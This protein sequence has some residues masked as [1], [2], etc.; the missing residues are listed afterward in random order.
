MAKSKAEYYFRRYLKIAPLGLALWR[1][2][3][4]KHL[5]R[6]KLPRP[7]L[8]VG[9]GFGEFALAF[10]DGKPVDVGIDILAKNL[11]NTV[12]TKK[13]KNLVIGDAREMP[14]SDNTFGSIFSISTYEHITHPDKLLKESYRVLRPGGIIFL[15][16]ETDEVDLNTFYRPLFKKIGIGS[17]SKWCTQ[18]YNRI[19]HRQTLLSKKEWIEKIKN[20]G[21]VI[22]KQ[23][24]IITPKVTKLFDIFLLTSWPAQLFYPLLGKRF[25]FRPPFAVDILTKLFVKYVEEEEKE[26]TNLLVIARK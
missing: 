4:A 6:I 24:S 17:F 26:G 13:Y 23:Q 3:E 1:S 15:T 11:Y 21:F 20:A 19:F 16:L 9:C 14:F 5:S 7:I 10:V 25:V 12:K 2:V 18:S 22:E 8:D